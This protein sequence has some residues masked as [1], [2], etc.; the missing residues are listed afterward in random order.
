MCIV[1]AMIGKAVGGRVGGIIGAGLGGGIPG[2][3][4]ASQV[5]KKPNKKQPTYAANP[6]GG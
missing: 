5:F 2:A 1:P 3:L 4:A 6:Y